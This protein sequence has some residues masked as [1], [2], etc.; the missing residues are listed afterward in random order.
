MNSNTDISGFGTQGSQPQI[1]TSGSTEV[2]AASTEA[3]GVISSQESTIKKSE[4]EKLAEWIFI[5]GLPAL[6][7]PEPKVT[8]QGSSEGIEG[9][10]GS[11]IL[12]FSAQVEQMTHDIIV[13]MWDKYA[14]TLKEI[15]K[16]REEDYREKWGKDL[17]KEGPKSATE[18]NA[19]LL[20]L[21]PTQRRDEIGPTGDDGLD[22]QFGA[23]YN[24]WLANPAENTS[25]SGAPSAGQ[26]PNATF[27]TG[28]IASSP[29]LVSQTMGVAG[30]AG[31]Q[32]SVSPIADALTALGPVSAL[33]ADSQL[34]V[35][36]VAALL[37]NGSASKANNDALEDA[38]KKGL[39]LTF[40]EFGINYAKNILA[41]ITHNVEGDKTA[42]REGNQNRLI[43]LLLATTALTALHRGVFDGVQ[44]QDIEDLI[45]TNNIDKADIPE[46]TKQLF[47]DLAAKVND[48]LN[49]SP[50]TREALIAQMAQYAGRKET[51][52]S[53]MSST[54]LLMATLDPPSIN[55]NR[56]AAKQ[57]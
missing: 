29:D 7:P 42:S 38:S 1:T 56:I 14:E 49:E 33:P 8:F 43:K 36:L 45:N 52:E 47:R 35:A 41:I 18:Y 55:S 20:A 24:R 25:A 4:L 17:A 10:H 46:E 32:L 37:Y 30:A 19:Y 50:E 54:K 34:A 3:A 44:P 5:A 12:T 13:D 22:V 26:Y 31:L 6:F 15:A 57:G 16:R 53:M 23:T 2:G 39:P 48:L 28:A 51:V 9:V 11:S 21:S 27:I 40:A